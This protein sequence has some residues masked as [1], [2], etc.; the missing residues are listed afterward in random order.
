MNIVK[1]ISVGYIM[2][3]HQ[4]I[5]SILMNTTMCHYI[6]KI[7]DIH[8]LNNHLFSSSSILKSSFYIEKWKKSKRKRS[9]AQKDEE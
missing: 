1:K 6:Q 5:E 9:T 4:P 7:F 3:S 8:I 2:A